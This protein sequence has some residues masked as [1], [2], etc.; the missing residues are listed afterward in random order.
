VSFR[1]QSL[2][3]FGGSWSGLDGQFIEGYMAQLDEFLRSQRASSFYPAEADIFKAFEA[4]PLEGVRVVI[5]GQDPYTDGSATGLAFSIPK[6]RELPP[7]LR[8]IYCELERDLG[9]PAA[10]CGDLTHWAA[11]GVLLLNS[12][13]TVRVNA[14]FRS[15]RCGGWWTRFT[16]QALKLIDAERP[17]VVS[18]LWGAQAEGK[19]KY[20]VHSSCDHMLTASHPSPKT[21]RKRLRGHP[22]FDGC[23]HF[24]EVNRLLEAQGDEPIRW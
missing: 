4:T 8:N 16:N 10:R 22:S 14:K 6:N 12:V 20:L 9:R 1:L 19:R 2:W 21:F 13:L 23:G 5:V 18:C 15:H 7:S 24:S 17:G 3:N 11:Q